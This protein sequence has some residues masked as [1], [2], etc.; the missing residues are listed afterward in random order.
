MNG[1][2]TISL[3]E[4]DNLVKINLYRNIIKNSFPNVIDSGILYDTDGNKY[5]IYNI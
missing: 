5:F 2:T 1:T 3:G 4:T